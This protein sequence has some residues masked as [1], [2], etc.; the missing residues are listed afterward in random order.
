MNAEKHH[1][2]TLIKNVLGAVAV[3]NVPID[4]ENFGQM[5]SYSGVMSGQSDVIEQAESHAARGCGMMTRRTHQA[6]RV[7]LGPFDDRI[8][9]RHAGPRRGQCNTKRIR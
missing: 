6:E 3:M 9:R 2:G 8:D 1:L 7:L 5:V 4:D